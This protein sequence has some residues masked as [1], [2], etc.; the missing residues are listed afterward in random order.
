[1]KM[2]RKYTKEYYSTIKKKEVMNFSGKC[3]DL[4]KIILSKVTQ[5]QKDKCISPSA[6]SKSSVVNAAISAHQRQ[7]L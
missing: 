3:V 2:W 1:M 7:S 5:I 6:V 4:E